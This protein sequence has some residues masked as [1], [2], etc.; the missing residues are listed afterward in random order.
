MHRIHG[1]IGAL[2]L[3]LTACGSAEGSFRD[4]LSTMGFSDEMA[5]CLID[6]LDARGLS[7]EDI[8]DEATG[9]G[10]LPAGAEEAMITCAGD[11]AR[12]VDAAFRAHR[13][14]TLV[15]GAH[16]FVISD[17]TYNIFDIDTPRREVGYDPVHNAETYYRQG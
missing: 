4:E 8:S 13:N 11:A 7:V 17:N 2:V 6:E 3:L 1:A 12:L 5:D 16:Y 9:D 10:E 14:G 15:S